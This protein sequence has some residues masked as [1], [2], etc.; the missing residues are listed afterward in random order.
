MPILFQPIDAFAQDGS[1]EVLYSNLALQFSSQNFN[2]DAGTGYFPSVA[3]P[4]VS[5]ISTS[6]YLIIR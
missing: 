3:A 5:A 1:N 2:G 6:A 4:K